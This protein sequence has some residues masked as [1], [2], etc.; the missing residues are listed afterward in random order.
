[1][2]AQALEAARK[3]ALAGER[4]AAV[5][6]KTMTEIISRAP[7]S[8]VDYV[9]VVDADTLQPLDTLAGK[10]ML[11]LAVRFGSTRLIDNILVDVND[12]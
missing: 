12:R 3:Q 9:A 5:L 11:A 7:G 10:A 4:R 6:L 1:M 2:L 8:K